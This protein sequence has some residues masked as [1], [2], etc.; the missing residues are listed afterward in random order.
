MI[1][2]SYF[3]NLKNIPKSITPI[4][5]ARITPD[6]YNGYTYKQLAPSAELL[7]EYKAYHDEEEYTSQF[8]EYLETL[9]ADDV[10]EDLLEFVQE[11]ES[12][13]I[14]LLCYETPDKFC[15]RNLVSEWLQDNY[16]LC[17]EWGNA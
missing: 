12:E 7:A 16:Y 14:C 8:L 17:E 3:G 11:N 5:I 9:D 6:W 13:D 2:T 4:S 1:Y 15:H 10:Y